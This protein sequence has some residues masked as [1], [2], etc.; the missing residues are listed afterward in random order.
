MPLK[1]YA[2]FS[3]ADIRLS[4]S[5]RERGADR[6]AGCCRQRGHASASRLREIRG[7][8]PA[9]CGRNRQRDRRSRVVRERD[10]HRGRLLSPTS[11]VPKGRL[12]GET[13]IVGTRGKSATNAFVRRTLERD[14]ICAAGHRQIGRGRLTGDY[15]FVPETSDRHKPRRM[16]RRLRCLQS[17]WSKAS[18]PVRFRQD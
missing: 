14:W 16:Y 13:E 4:R 5:R 18:R 3:V 11:C 17:N 7:I 8:R 9:D 15:A 1:V 6:A 10:E 2:I 12:V